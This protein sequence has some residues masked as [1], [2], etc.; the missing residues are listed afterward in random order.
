MV[1]KILW[2]CGKWL[3]KD[4]PNYVQE[5][6]QTWKDKNPTWEIKYFDNNQC[7]KL[8]KKI[9]GNEAA[10]IFNTIPRGDNK[11]DFWRVI[12]LN[13]YGGFYADLDT[14]CYEPIE[15]WANLNKDFIV[16]KNT[17]SDIGTIWENWCF[18]ATKDNIILTEIIT[19][20]NKEINNS[21]E[22]I[23]ANHTFFPFTKTVNKYVNNS[24]V[25]AICPSYAFK[26]GHIAA[27]DN[28]DN[29]EYFANGGPKI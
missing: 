22:Q 3:E 14:K 9:L 4:I 16:T 26:V 2:Q 21:N 23:N 20:I 17:Y 13:A 15:S 11:A 25:Q 28:W 24:W 7:F 10:N 19:K 6:R 5:Y 27:H 1:P 18:G 8:I 29:S 12:T